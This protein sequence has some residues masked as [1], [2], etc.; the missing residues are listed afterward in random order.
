M[1]VSVL[2]PVKQSIRNDLLALID[3]EAL[4]CLPGMGIYPFLDSPHTQA[5]RGAIM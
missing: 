3:L 2:L 5:N 4:Y 1:Q